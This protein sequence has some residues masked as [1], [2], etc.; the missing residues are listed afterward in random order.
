MGNNLIYRTQGAL[1][2]GQEKHPVKVIKGFGITYQEAQPQPI[3]DQ[4][5][6]INCE[7]IPDA[8]PGYIENIKLIEHE[9]T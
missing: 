2:A 1:E 4:W 3:A 6:F 8:L 9:R 5:L 7:N